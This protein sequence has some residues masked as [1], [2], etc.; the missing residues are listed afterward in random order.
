MGS[1]PSETELLF[2]RFEVSLCRIEVVA[3][4]RTPRLHADATANATL[5]CTL[6]GRGNGWRCR[7]ADTGP[8]CEECR[9]AAQPGNRRA[10]EAIPCLAVPLPICDA[11]HASNPPLASGRA[12]AERPRN[13]L[14]A[15]ATFRLIIFGAAAWSISA[16]EARVRRIGGCRRNVGVGGNGFGGQAQ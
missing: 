9:S 5:S 4:V 11:A 13:A 15:M 3:L 16:L 7:S 10:F 1:E 12:P 6:C 8:T 2:R 14:V